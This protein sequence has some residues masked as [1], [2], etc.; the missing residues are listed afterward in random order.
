MNVTTAG[1]AHL[2]DLVLRMADEWCEGRLVSV[3][4][5]GYALDALCQSV[6]AHLE[7]LTDSAEPE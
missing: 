3:L 7:V 1:F 4:E 2:T 5:G 6:L